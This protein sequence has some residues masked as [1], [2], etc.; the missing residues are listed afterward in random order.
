[1][2]K[3]WSNNRFFADVLN[4]NDYKILE[5]RRAKLVSPFA[6]FLTKPNEP[7]LLKKKRINDAVLLSYI[8]SRCARLSN[9]HAHWIFIVKVSRHHHFLHWGGGALNESLNHCW[10]ITW[11]K[12]KKMDIDWE[13]SQKAVFDPQWAL[14]N[15][16]LP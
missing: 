6:H 4:A 5:F 2:T 15:W 9:I 11:L 10:M 7:F 1:M 13:R 3:L 8:C 16:S 12:S 14:L